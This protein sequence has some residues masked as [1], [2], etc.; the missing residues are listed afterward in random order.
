MALL[1]SPTETLLPT[2]ST[3]ALI[4]NAM[5]QLLL[6][7]ASQLCIPRRG[8]L[9]LIR[10]GPNALQFNLDNIAILQ[11]HLRVPA[12]PHALRSAAIT[13]I[14]NRKPTSEARKGKSTHVPVKMTS[15]GI[16]V[17]P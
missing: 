5:E 3:W 4:I 17:V 10:A 11:P 6:N 12:H 9:D 16:S 1:T 14:S 8:K 7:L 15:P 13:Q 2:S